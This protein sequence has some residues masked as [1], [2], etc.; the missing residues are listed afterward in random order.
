MSEQ[1]LLGGGVETLAPP[2]VPPA[3]FLSRPM[4]LRAPGG[5]PCAHC[6]MVAVRVAGHAEQHPPWTDRTKI[7]VLSAVYRI[8]QVDGSTLDLCAQH[9]AE[10]AERGRQD[11]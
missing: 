7:T 10:H 8:T 6:E 1:L 5:L 9:A 2:P 11:G 3:V 4:R